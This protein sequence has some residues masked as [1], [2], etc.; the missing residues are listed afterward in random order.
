MR[1]SLTLKLTAVVLSVSLISVILV[2]VSIRYFTVSAFDRLIQDRVL[3][4]FVA[5]VTSY[6]ETNGSWAGVD[7]AF[8]QA[9]EP[10]APNAPNFPDV[11]FVLVDQSGLVVIPDRRY[12]VGQ[13]VQIDQLNRGTP[14]ELDGEVI[15]TVL[16]G[17]PP[18][19]R[20]PAESLYLERTNRALLLAAGGTIVLAVLLG[21]LWARTLTRP[22]RELTAATHKLAQ[23]ALEQQVPVRT[24]DELGQL[25]AS[26]NR[27]SG[28]LARSNQA[29][30]QMTADIAHDLRT[31]LTVIKG[32]TEALRDG[33]LPPTPETFETMHQEA[34]HLSRLIDDLRTLSLAD[35]G[36]LVL[37]CRP[38]PPGDLLA[39]TLAAYRPQA[40]AAGIALVVEVEDELPHVYVDPDR[41]ARVLGNLIGNALRYTSSGGQVTLVAFAEGDGVRLRV[42][43]DGAG[44]A[45]EDLPHVFDRFYR[46][47]PARQTDGSESGL[48]LAIAKSLVEAQGGAIAAQSTLGWGTTFE[49]VLP[50]LSD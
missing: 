43:D 21:S 47:D 50:R 33:D 10:D 9:P 32:Y 44:I 46:G 35:A 12:F 38:T 36:E 19:A 3:E 17:I 48:G 11:D 28:D 45:P 40:E 5:A 18:P 1:R 23:G 20:N 34:E 26:F 31:P 41:M 13:L 49:I 39:Q 2:A 30:R 16:A 25:A 24:E 42:S 27:M 4:E 15:G 7:L 14:V 37:N 8:R 22:L 6:Y 29:R